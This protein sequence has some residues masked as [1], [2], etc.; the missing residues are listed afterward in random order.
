MNAVK[1][2]K[3]QHR[4]VKKLF[5]EALS[6]SSPAACEKATTEVCDQLAVHATIEEKI[7]YPESMM[8]K[9]EDLLREAVEEH[10]GAKRVI[11]DIMAA[12]P[13]DPQY[14]AKVTVLKE[15]IEHHVEEEE[16]TLFPR[17]EKL[18]GD[19]KLK[20]MGAR[21]E[22]MSQALLSKGEPRDVVPSETK[23]PAPLPAP[24]AG[25][26]LNGSRSETRA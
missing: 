3:S 7:F 26:H 19:D 10:L 14:L 1:L 16:E 9:T 21:M 2:L 25:S 6:A 12:T 22:Q 15:M 18:L 23:S 17:V 24:K 8:E 13:S 4:Q 20:E 5:S 11:A